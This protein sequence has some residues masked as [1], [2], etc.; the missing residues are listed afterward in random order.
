MTLGERVTTVGDS[1]VRVVGS[2]ETVGEG[3]EARKLSVVVGATLSVEKPGSPMPVAKD[4]VSSHSLYHGFIRV[5]VPGVQNPSF[6][7]FKRSSS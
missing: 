1:I 2:A 6:A 5:D 4:R 3:E 7:R